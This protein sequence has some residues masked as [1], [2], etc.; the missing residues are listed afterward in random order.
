[1]SPLRLIGGW[2]A[3]AA[4]GAAAAVAWQLAQ[5]SASVQGAPQDGRVVSAITASAEGR[6]LYLQN[7]ASCHGTNGQGVVVAGRQGEETILGP[8]LEDAGT[9]S[10]QFYLATGRMPMSAP[11][12]PSYRQPVRFSH[13]EIA[14]LITYGQTLGDG[15]AIP[16]VVTDLS[17]L[18]AGWALY[19]N[20][21]A[22]C[23]GMTGTGGAVGPGS[24][25]PSI[26]NTQATLLADAVLVGPGTMP[27]FDWTDE[28]LSAV[29]TYVESLRRGAEGG[30]ITIGGFG[31]VTEGLIAGFVGLAILVL[32]A[33]F[34]AG[35]PPREEEPD[36]AAAGG[37]D[38]A[39]EPPDDG[40]SRSGPT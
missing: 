20:N 19:T 22:A 33:L 30:S 10:W 1:M 23:H 25:A 21:C 15:R 35:R 26:V 29:A 7:C 2:I 16:D 8:S 5:T 39:P 34:V 6:R 13:E 40:L 3:L 9:A 31:P 24:I 17:S 38:V 32:V 14:A 12:D 36:L 11:G 18:Q 4:I 37:G 28:Q 27:R